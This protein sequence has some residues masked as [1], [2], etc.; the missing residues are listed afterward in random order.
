MKDQIVV[1]SAAHHCWDRS[2]GANSLLRA[3]RN[4]GSMGWLIRSA[5]AILFPGSSNYLTESKITA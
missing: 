3:V 1:S 5:V 2:C 4:P